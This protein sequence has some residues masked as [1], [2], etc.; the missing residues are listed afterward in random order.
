MIQFKNQL[1]EIFLTV[2]KMTNSVKKEYKQTSTLQQFSDSIDIC[3]KGSQRGLGELLVILI[4]V[5]F[6]TTQICTYVTYIFPLSDLIFNFLAAYCS[7]VSYQLI[8]TVAG[9]LAS[10]EGF[11]FYWR[12][13]FNWPAKAYFSS[14]FQINKTLCWSGQ[15]R[16]CFQERNL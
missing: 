12:I 13:K 9:L 16:E 1:V 8:E 4:L 5:N 7:A 10:N 11:K 14:P 6:Y 2:L 3:L 15:H